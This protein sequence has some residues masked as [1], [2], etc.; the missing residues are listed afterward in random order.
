MLI[1]LLLLDL[2]VWDDI[3]AL[4]P[5]QIISLVCYSEAFKNNTS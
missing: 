5:K 1:T 2:F 4:Q 3:L